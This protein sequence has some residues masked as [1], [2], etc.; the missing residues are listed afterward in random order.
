MA[1]IAEKDPKINT[2]NFKNLLDAL[3]L[4]LPGDTIGKKSKFAVY[5][6]CHS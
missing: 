1:A 2:N 5:A 3:S 4:A 6:C